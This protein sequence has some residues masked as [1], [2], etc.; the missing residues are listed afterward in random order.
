MIFSS[1]LGPEGWFAW[2]AM[3]LCRAVAAGLKDGRM[4]GPTIVLVCRRVRRVERLFLALVE[5][6]RSGRYRGGF[7]RAPAACLPGAP[8][9]GAPLPGAPLPHAPLPHAPLPG[10]PLP[11]APFK[12]ATQGAPREAGRSLPRRFGWLIGLLP[13]EAVAYASQLSCVLADAEVAALL[14]DVPQARRIL[15]PLCVMLG[16]RLD[17]AEVVA[18]MVAGEVAG[19]VA[20][21]RRAP[22][23]R[24][25]VVRGVEPFRIPLPRGVL[26]AA[27]RQGFG[28]MG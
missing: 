28:K 5:R 6:V 24:A 26:A 1:I 16:V 4:D 20:G 2:I 3:A 14:R 12:G 8:L 15:R 23:P 13:C 21:V 19:V 9:P 22:A 27:R 11:H 10:A 17:P 25:R 7:A 18:E